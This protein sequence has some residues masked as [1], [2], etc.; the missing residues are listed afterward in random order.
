MEN[1]FLIKCSCGWKRLSTGISEDLK[2]LKE[3]KKCN[4]CGGPRKFKC[5]KCGKVAKQFRIKGNS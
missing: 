5:P 3:V 1:R 2:D 4:N